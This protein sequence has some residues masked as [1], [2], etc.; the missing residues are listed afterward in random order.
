MIRLVLILVLALAVA[1]GAIW[2]LKE[3][4]ARWR[5]RAERGAEYVETRG[6][7]DNAT[8]NVRGLDDGGILDRLRELAE[9]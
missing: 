2:V 9:P 1:L 5:E 6:E 4:A 8:E 3:Q 7:I